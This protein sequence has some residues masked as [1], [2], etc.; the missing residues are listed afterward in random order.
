MT[1]SEKDGPVP[2]PTKSWLEGVR[3]EFVTPPWRH[4]EIMTRPAPADTVAVMQEVTRPN[5]WFGP[6]TSQEFSGTVTPDGFI[7]SRRVLS[8]NSFVPVITGRLEWLPGRTRIRITMRLNWFVLA[9]WFLFMTFAASGLLT[10]LTHARAVGGNLASG[11]VPVA[12]V[13]VFGYLLCAVSFGWEARWAKG[14]LDPLL[15]GDV[16][17]RTSGGGAQPI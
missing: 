15:S 10:V 12:G 7:V 8:R 13:L 6:K 1:V 2:T 5:R 9:V 17:S 14:R 3:R 11:L 4:Y 16:N